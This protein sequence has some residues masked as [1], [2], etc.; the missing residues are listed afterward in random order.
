L[1]GAVAVAVAVEVAVAVAF[2]K[3]P[4]GRPNHT[5]LRTI[6]LDLRPLN[7]GPSYTW[8]KAASQEHWHL[9]VDMA[10]LQKSVPLRERDMHLSGK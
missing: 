9:I 7:I 8:K 2:G 3:R 6:E 5:W 1:D 4:P 10:I